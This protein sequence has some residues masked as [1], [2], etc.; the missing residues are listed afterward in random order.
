MQLTGALAHAVVLQDGDVEREEVVECF[1]G[2]GRRRCDAHSAAIKSE[3]GSHLLEDEGIGN[4]PSEWQAAPVTKITPGEDTL[5]GI[6]DN[7]GISFCTTEFTAICREK[8]RLQNKDE[9]QYF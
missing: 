5:G 7:T 1:L 2:D 6:S 9:P 8:H 4:T 3:G